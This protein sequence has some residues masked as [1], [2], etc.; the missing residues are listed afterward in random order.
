MDPEG[1]E[2]SV[3]LASLAGAEHVLG[4]LL[5]TARVSAPGVEL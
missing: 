1:M 5:W 4:E 3:V 2:T